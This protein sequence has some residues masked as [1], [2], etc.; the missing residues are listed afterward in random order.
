MTCARCIIR[1]PATHTV[2]GEHVC[3]DHAEAAVHAL[4]PGVALTIAAL[5]PT[6]QEVPA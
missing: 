4:T 6:P 5:A 1:R 3:R 2:N